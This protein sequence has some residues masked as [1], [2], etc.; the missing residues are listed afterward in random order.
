MNTALLLIMAGCACVI[1]FTMILYMAGIR[2]KPLTKL[3]QN[4][5]GYFGSFGLILYLV[6]AVCFPRHSLRL[7][8]PNIEVYQGKW[9]QIQPAEA[10]KFFR[11][12]IR[13]N[14]G[15][16]IFFGTM[17]MYGFVIILSAK[18]NELSEDSSTSDGVFGAKKHID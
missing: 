12:N 10:E 16:L 14:I 9:M 3:A 4:V 11:K 8:G 15:A 6:T 5:V 13:R 1:L 18:P 7:N 2:L 17:A